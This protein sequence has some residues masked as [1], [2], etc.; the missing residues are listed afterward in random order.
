[1]DD[2]TLPIEVGAKFDIAFYF[3][4]SE[5]TDPTKCLIYI[6]FLRPC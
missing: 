6:Q 4:G 1:M 5:H 3:F 2:Q